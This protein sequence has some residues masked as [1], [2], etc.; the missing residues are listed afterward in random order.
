MATEPTDAQLETLR[1]GNSRQP[2]ALLRLLRVRDAQAFKHYSEALDQTV[3]ASGGRTPYFGRVD[4]AAVSWAPDFDEIRIDEFPSREHCA[5]SLSM[6][7]P[8]TEA[9]LADA[10]VLA[11]RPA[12]LTTR[13]LIRVASTLLRTFAHRRVTDAPPFPGAGEPDGIFT[14]H[15]AISHSPAQARTFMEAEQSAPFAMVNL[16]I[17][18]DRAAYDPD[19]DEPEPDVSGAVANRRYARVALPNVLRRGGR[20]I[21]M[22]S[23]EGIVCGEADHPLSAPWEDFVLVFY[24]SRLAMRD[25]LANAHYRSGLPHRNAGLARAGLYATTPLQR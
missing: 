14:D 21:H 20:P 22:G 15:T 16:N 10:F 17:H 8:H 18:R 11:Y 25:M 9:A 24:P 7:N 1:N 23:V 12:S 4:Q 13:L 2:L 3:R 5:D 19:F 6:R